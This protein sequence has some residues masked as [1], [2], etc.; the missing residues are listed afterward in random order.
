MERLYT[1]WRMNYVTTTH[2]KAEGCVFC[3]KLE[4]GPEFDRG[5]FVV[6]HGDTTF[7]VMNIF[8]YNTGHLMVLP[9]EHVAKLSEL[10]PATH[11]EI[12]G[13][14]AH[15]V[16]LLT[17]LMSPDGFN[18][19]IN[20]GRVA[21]AG[22]DSHLHMHIVPRWSGDSNFMGVV[23]D[24]KVLPETLGDTYNRITALLKEYPPNLLK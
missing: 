5:N 6:Y 16:E 15:F 13:L 7:V 19:G 18:I 22:I 12:M 9:Y 3:A 11:Q 20:L 14:T 23:G 17:Q 2:K 10:T 4:A 8:P 24:T 21:G 1:P